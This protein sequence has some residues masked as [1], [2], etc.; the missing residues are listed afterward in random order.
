MSR[1]F[2]SA[3]RDRKQ[4]VQALLLEYRVSRKPLETILAEE[5]LQALFAARASASS[6]RM[7]KDAACGVDSPVAA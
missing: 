7:L 1:R 4:S 2:I 5:A 3:T 6:H